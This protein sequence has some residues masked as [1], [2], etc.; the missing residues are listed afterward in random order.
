MKRKWD[1][2]SK[3][4]RKKCIE[5][6]IARVDEQEGAVF[7]VVAAEEVMDIVAQNLGPDIYN[8]AINDA[9]KLVLDHSSDI[10]AELDLLQNQS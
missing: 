1:L 8:L 6:I 2:S 10:E 9:K 7:G 3:E 5:E 4:T